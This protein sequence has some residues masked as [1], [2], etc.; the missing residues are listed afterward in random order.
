MLAR[1]F[2]HLVTK[3]WGIE[4]AP[5]A[6]HYYSVRYK[7]KICHS[8][9]KDIFLRFKFV[10]KITIFSAALLGRIKIGPFLISE[11]PLFFVDKI[12][13]EGNR[14]FK[15]IFTRADLTWERLLSINTKQLMKEEDFYST[16]QNDFT[17]TLSCT[18]TDLA[19]AVELE[20][21][22]HYYYKKQ[23]FSKPISTGDPAEMF[24]AVQQGFIKI[25]GSMPSVAF[26]RKPWSLGDPVARLYPKKENS[27]CFL[28]KSVH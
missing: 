18:E 22:L 1:T 26:Y 10:P 8:Y 17:L 6:S 27:L 25:G 5:I 13:G 4:W 2:F 20:A 9:E 21:F 24:L 7:T 28:T 14:S 11:S 16:N 15:R 3:K 19:S 12:E 23:L